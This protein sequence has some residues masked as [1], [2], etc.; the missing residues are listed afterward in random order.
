ME[1]H[2]LEKRILDRLVFLSILII[3]L[4]ALIQTIH[5]VLTN[6]KIIAEEEI[7]TYI[8]LLAYC[9][10]YLMI[11]LKFRFTLIKI[12]IYVIFYGSFIGGFFNVNGF[13]G[14]TALDMSNVLITGIFLFPSLRGR[15]VIITFHSMMVIILLYI[16]IYLPDTIRYYITINEKVTITFGILTR[17]LLGI[18]LAVVIFQEYKKEQVKIRSK[19][20]VIQNLNTELQKA[21]TSFK[22]ANQSLA[23][24]VE[25]LKTTQ[26]QLVQNKKMASI[27]ILTAGVAH[28]I[29][30][31]LNYIM[32]AYVGLEKI[33]AE[34][35]FEENASTIPV[36]L[37]SL[38]TGVERASGIVISLK[39]FSR[40]TK[41][42]G[43]ECNLHGIIDNCLVILNNQIKH[44]I[45][46][47]KNFNS[48]EIIIKGNAGNLHQVFL[49]II[50]NAI[51]A[52][53]D[54]GQIAIEAMLENQMV[55]ITISD[56]GE[57]IDPENLK[58]ITDPF[59]TTKDPGKGTGLGLSITYSI[60]KS[61][62]GTLDFQSEKGKG[63]KVRI[64]FPVI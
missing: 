20:S 30:N 5:S 45:T 18:N 1:D 14:I 42:L 19:N 37:E 59:F 61:H 62:M 25:E 28:E 8:V 17:L 54:E 3:V 29:N 47:H 24:T 46:I 56:N 21:N 48:S 31:P 27:G 13:S 2:Q 41:S 22:E 26:E 63:T 38:K 35:S 32:G 4:Y 55:T 50:G 52:I 9:S 40:D 10:Y 43:E 11:R 33:F 7:F 57:G 15:I 44:R 58:K 34:K 39:Q 49:N 23:Q 12:I 51:Q 36:L 53:S 64:R 16:N 6:G 60:V